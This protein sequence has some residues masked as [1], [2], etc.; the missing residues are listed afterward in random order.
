MGSWAQVPP[1]LPATQPAPHPGPKPLMQ[2]H[3]YVTNKP[4]PCAS[5]QELQKLELSHAAAPAG[6]STVFKV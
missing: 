2:V 6:G 1:L 3:L 4:V 5:L